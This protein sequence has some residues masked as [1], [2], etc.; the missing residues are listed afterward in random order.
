M[1]AG[2]LVKSSLAD[3]YYFNLNLNKRKF[4]NMNAYQIKTPHL[5][6]LMFAFNFAFSNWTMTANHVWRVQKHL[7]VC[8]MMY[9]EIFVVSTSAIYV[10]GFFFEK[11]FTL[12]NDRVVYEFS[13][14]QMMNRFNIRKRTH[15]DRVMERERE[16]TTRP[17]LG[18]RVAN[19]IS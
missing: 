15:A 14:V 10:S 9:D 16:N 17:I 2:M 18:H 13:I 1:R 3:Y 5:V 12:F 7:F 19:Y 8:D 11:V 4:Q 6:F